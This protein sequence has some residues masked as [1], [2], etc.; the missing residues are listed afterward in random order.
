MQGFEPQLC[1]NCRWLWACPPALE[2]SV[3]PGE[4]PYQHP[5]AGPRNKGLQ[6]CAQQS[7]EGT[8]QPAPQRHHPRRDRSPK[9]P[10]VGMEGGAN[11]SRT[12][13]AWGT[14]PHRL[15]A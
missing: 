2:P 12:T 3:P 10:N 14:P 5:R 7:E 15:Q 4:R 11:A 1:Y 9:E 13:E 6:R 8:V